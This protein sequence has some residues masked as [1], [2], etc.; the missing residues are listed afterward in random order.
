MIEEILRHPAF[1]GLWKSRTI[2]GEKIHEGWSVTFVLDGNYCEVP[3][4]DTPELAVACALEC[5][6]ANSSVDK[7]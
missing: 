6:N 5:L 3:Y 2:D 4:H 7:T 1:R